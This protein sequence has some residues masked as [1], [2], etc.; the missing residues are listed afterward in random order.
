MRT[1]LTNRKNNFIK[2]TKVLGIAALTCLGLKANAQQQCIASYTYVNDNI[3]AGNVIF[4][5]TSSTGNSQ[6]TYFW[7][8]GDGTSSNLENPN[9]VFANTGTSEVVVCLTIYD[10]VCQSTFCDTVITGGITNVCQAYFYSTPDSNSVNGINFFNY[11]NSGGTPNTSYSWYF[12]DNSTS[13]LQNP[14]HI[15]ASAGTYQVCLTISDSNGIACSYCDNVVV[16]NNTG[17]GCMAYFYAE[18]DLNSANGINF[19]NYSSLGGAPS[20][21]NS[22]DFGDNTAVSNLENPNHIYTNAG[23]YMVCLTITDSNGV[24]CS[25]C[26]NVVVQDSTSVGCQA[27]FYSEPDFNSVNGINFFNYSSPGGTPSSFSWDFGDNTPVSNVANPNHIYANEGTYTVCLTAISNGVT[28]S[29]CDYVIVGDNTG[30]GCQAYF[31][32]EPDSNSVNGINFFN[33]SNSDGISNTLSW[34]FGD[35]TV[36]SNQENPNHIYAN[37]GTYMVC[38]TIVDSNGTTCSY[39]DNIIVGDQTGGTCQAYFYAVPDSNSVNGMSFVNYSGINS[40]GT[41]SL[42]FWDFGDNTTSNQENPS[43]VYANPGTYQVCLTIADS[44]GITCVNCEDIVVGDGGCQAYFYWESDS[45]SVNGI[46]FSNNNQGGMLNTNSYL[47]NFGD[48][49]TSSNLGAPNHVYADTGTYYPCLTIIS[50]NGSTC[51]YCDSIAV[52]AMSPSGINESRNVN[53]NVML[54]NYPNPFSG[55]TTIK[56]KLSKGTS[57]ELSVLDILG[58]KIATIENAHKNAGNY[59]VVWNADN[60]A[61]GVYFLRMN[62]NDQISIKKVIVSK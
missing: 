7:S 5:N 29:Y 62:V 59:S 32:A 26:D 47:W 23:T 3:N 53:A 57:V 35:N 37:T 39:C 41:A 25:Y 52:L 46:S 36:G 11:S 51:T 42:F 21:S 56:Y 8:F 24:S 19:W 18:P 49:T 12:G 10:S 33:Y 60:V 20:G 16:G 43:H 6:L 44:N 15:Y 55:N 22:W 34:D 54:E 2:L 48:N 13:S 9:H 31:Y 61:E 17:S 50:Q 14:N 45:S 27:Y 40:G 1:T 30:S 58:N 4:T 38:L 28:C